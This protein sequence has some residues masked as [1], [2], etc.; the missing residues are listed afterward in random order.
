QVLDAPVNLRGGPGTAYPALTD[1]LAGGTVLEPLGRNASGSWLNVRVQAT[2]RRG[3]VIA[4]PALIACSVPIAELPVVA[5]PPPPPP[6]PPPRDRAPRRRRGGWRP[7]PPPP[8]QPPLPPHQSRPS[9]NLRRH[10]HPSHRLRGRRHPPLC[11]D[12]PT[13]D[14][15]APL[16]VSSAHRASR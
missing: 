15:T 6:P 14:W 11:L 2:G 12:K 5:P 3:W 8:T 13:V 4:K 7:P 9:H 10:S 16:V 1:S